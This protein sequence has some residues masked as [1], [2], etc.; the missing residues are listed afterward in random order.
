MLTMF[1]G[2]SYAVYCARWY[3]GDGS[4]LLLDSLPVNSR[5]EAMKE[6]HKRQDDHDKETSGTGKTDIVQL[7]IKSLPKY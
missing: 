2:H 6:A 5:A 1:Q 7:I 4:P 3:I